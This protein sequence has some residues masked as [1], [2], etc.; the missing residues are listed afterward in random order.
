MAGG[1]AIRGP[2]GNTVTAGRGAAFANGQFVGG[3]SWTRGERRLHPLELLY[4]GMVRGIPRRLV[5]REVGRRWHCLD[6]GLLGHSRR[7]L[8]LHRRRRYYDYADNVKYDNGIVYY[9]DEPVA[10]AEQYYDQADQ[11][12]DANAAARRQRPHNGLDHLTNCEG[13]GF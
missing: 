9:G 11:I 6:R 13:S 4:T 7:V 2:G 3:R 1:A 10:S 8:R 5:A 12:A